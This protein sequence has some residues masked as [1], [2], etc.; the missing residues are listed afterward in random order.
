MPMALISVREVADY[1]GLP[2]PTDDYSLLSR[3]I[4]AAQAGI[5]GAAPGCKLTAGTAYTEYHDSRERCVYVDHAPIT[6]IA[7]VVDDVQYSA[8]ELSSANW[9]TDANDG[10]KNYSVGKVELW[11]DESG[12]AGGRLAVRVNYTGG[13]TAATLPADLKQGWIEFT[14]ILYDSRDRVDVL[15][16]NASLTVIDLIPKPLLQVFQRY[17]T[18]YGV[19]A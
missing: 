6:A 2:D 17:Q 7:H 10:G 13:W 14:M 11:K 9:V 16:A 19:S 3:L 12:F 8:R 15:S 18:L 4:D 5:E 1:I